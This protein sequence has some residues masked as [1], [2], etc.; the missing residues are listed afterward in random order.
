MSLSNQK[1]LNLYEKLIETGIKKANNKDFTDAEEDF[2]KAIKL[3]DKNQ[4]AHINLSNVYIIQK[5]INKAVKILMY[6]IY[7][8]KNNDMILNHTAKFLYSYNLNDDLLDLFHQTKLNL[9][10]NN[11][12]N[13]YLYFIQGLY[14]EKEENYQSAK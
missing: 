5:K 14:F 3:N 2:S 1:N 10:K 12:K 6:Y 8:Y 13:Y 4:I 9:K 7:K 11:N